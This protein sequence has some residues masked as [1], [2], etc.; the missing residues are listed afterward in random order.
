MKTQYRMQA[1]GN[2]R[3][4]PHRRPRILVQ[5]IEPVTFARCAFILICIVLGIYGVA[6]SFKS[7]EI[8]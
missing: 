4:V 1:S 5:I 8:C 3:R 6:P 2:R 7:H